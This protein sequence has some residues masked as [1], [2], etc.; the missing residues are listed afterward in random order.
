[1]RQNP[2]MI[3][4]S[5]TPIP[6]QFSIMKLNTIQLNVLYC[7]S[8]GKRLINHLTL[9]VPNLNLNFTF[10]MGIE[11]GEIVIAA[12]FFNQFITDNVC[13]LG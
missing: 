3:Q 10:I 11:R 8:K 7:R 4:F 5:E 6:R 2:L 1:M 12:L 9:I 13:I